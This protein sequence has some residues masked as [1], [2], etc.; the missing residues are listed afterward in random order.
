[1]ATSKDHRPF[2]R[3]RL[4]SPSPSAWITR[5][6]PL[7]PAGSRILDLACGSGRHL[8]LLHA[9]GY[10]LTGVDRD[11]TAL[12]DL[13]GKESI[14][15]LQADLEDDSPFPL[16]GRQFE[17][18]IV[19]NYLHRPLL[20]GLMALVA[21]GGLLLYET[22]A[23]GNERF[24]R[25]SNPDFLLQPGELLAA[26]AGQLQVVAYEHGEVTVPRPGVVQRIAARRERGCSGK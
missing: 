15:L 23:V 2:A 6:L 1:M 7:L 4:A 26:V 17:G 21:P 12:E 10:R 25:P 8:R 16:T 24:G 13:Q 22:F 5:F 3:A 14:E 20:P 11:L 19:T 9:L 18:V